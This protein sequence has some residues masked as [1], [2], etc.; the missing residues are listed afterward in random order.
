MGHGRP[1]AD[2]TDAPD[3]TERAAGGDRSRGTDADRLIQPDRL[4]E[5]PCGGR[6]AVWQVL[7]HCLR[8]V[9]QAPRVLCGRPNRRGDRGVADESDAEPDVIGSRGTSRAPSMTS[10]A[11]GAASRRCRSCS[12]G[13][14]RERLRPPERLGFEAAGVGVAV[15]F[16]HHGVERAHEHRHEGAEVDEPEPDVERLGGREGHDPEREEGDAEDNSTRCVPMMSGR[17]IPARGAH[18]GGGAVEPGDR[19]EACAE[20]GAGEPGEVFGIQGSVM[21][22]AP[23]GFGVGV[24][25]GA[26][27]GA[28]GRSVEGVAISAWFEARADWTRAASRMRR[29]V[30]AASSPRSTHL[31]SSSVSGSGGRPRPR[32]GGARSGGQSGCGW[33]DTRRSRPWRTPLSDPELSTNSVIRSR[34]SRSSEARGWEVMGMSLVIRALV[35][36]CVIEFT[37][38]GTEFVVLCSKFFRKH[39]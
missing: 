20:N 39:Q 21:G 16:D 34:S 23:C 35:G 25:W 19:A 38:C 36:D 24:G 15:A 1:S 37:H 14:N 8:H 2:P 28:P 7:V 17:A 12:W 10:S 3:G 30:P 29:A 22:G 4:R 33:W 5:G 26:G 11:R 31:A 18:A 6:G 27:S 13:S 32:R 9:R